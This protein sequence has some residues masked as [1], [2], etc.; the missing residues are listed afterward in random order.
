MVM[1]CRGEMKLFQLCEWRMQCS[2]FR[3]PRCVTAAGV[4]SGCLQLNLATRCSAESDPSFRHCS[5]RVSLST[6]HPPTLVLRRCRQTGRDCKSTTCVCG[7]C[8]RSSFIAAVKW[9]TNSAAVVGRCTVSV[10]R[11]AI[12]VN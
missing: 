10:A 5:L 4:V 11:S 2:T 12:F 3:S 6:L 1:L 9:S 8:T 7:N